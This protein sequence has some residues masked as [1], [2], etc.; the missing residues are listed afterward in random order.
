MP[1][2]GQVK[3]KFYIV[4][5]SSLL[6]P[7]RLIIKDGDT[8]GVFDRFGDILPVGK[9][10][11]GIYHDG[12]RFLSQYEMSI[13]GMRP[14]LLS[15]NVDGQ[16]MFLTAD[17]TNTDLHEGG[18]IAIK[19][20]TIHIM[21]S[22]VILNAYCHEHIRLKN[23]GQEHI[24]FDLEIQFDSDF[25]DVFEVRGL[26]RAKRGKLLPPELR[27][28]ELILAYIGLDGKRRTTLLQ[29][30]HDARKGKTKNAVGFRIRLKPGG[31][32]YLTITTSCLITED[33][34]E[35][36]GKP[37]RPLLFDEA[38]KLA[39]KKLRALKGLR[40]EIFTSNQQF[41]QAMS[42]SI[43]DI[44]MML[45]ETEYG[46]YPYGG[47]PWFA[48]PFGRDGIIT[49]LESLWMKPD[50]AK[51]VLRYLGA[52]QARD[53]NKNTV[54]EPGKILHE[55]RKGE[56]AALGEIPFGLYYG[57]VDST[58]LY[59]MLAGAYWRRTGDTEFIKTIWDN[60]E[61]AL[62][63]IENYGDLDGDGFL[64]YM[65][66]KEGLI[67]QGWKDSADSIFHADGS[68]PKGPIALCEV[69]GYA[70]AARVE[71]AALAR[72]AGKHNYAEK[73]LK[74]AYMLKKKFDRAFWDEEMGTYILALDGGKSPCRV[75]ASNAG[76]TLFT[77][78]AFPQRAARVA[79]KLLSDAVFSGWGVRTLSAKEI[80]YNPISYHNG[81]VWPH[82]NALIAYGLA[83]YGRKKEFLK[84]F[85]A[86]FDAALSLFLE[87][88]RLPEL[89]CGFHRR[90]GQ[91]PTQYP[92]ACR[93]Q[94]WASG[95]LP[96]MLKAS[97][98]LEFEPREQ[99]VIFNNPVLPEFLD[100]VSLKNLYLS[101]RKSIDLAI[102]RHGESVT[103]EILRK[104]PGVSIISIK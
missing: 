20:D 53:F 49:A 44:Q 32:E 13:K 21:R 10:E 4:A 7:Q 73:L 90:P 59:V 102:T 23:F 104:P 26:K 99:K 54:A 83:L 101:P 97:L 9:G 29:F 93:P 33:G 86:L 72:L 40:C 5:I 80:L 84:I 3:D 95:T 67:N 27:R 25:A 43:S 63:W 45:T 89:F 36:R 94:A 74:D 55:T 70:Y 71:G 46:L 58:P 56:M 78:I 87:N 31:E 103:V 61:L 19:R 52:R 30:S 62:L 17:L 57:S 66:H 39:F 79:E 1:A 96:L 81:S 16:S 11:Q 41:N 65:P 69:Q 85:S 64:E 22:R 98:G 15:S 60:I 77:G 34:S 68:F 18:E 91:A 6:D 82:D 76:H 14:F 48:T 38:A 92:V 88:N 28:K 35:K 100:R 37:P 8:F 47:I 42:K 51:G 50:I 75:T 24:E 12:T 2:A